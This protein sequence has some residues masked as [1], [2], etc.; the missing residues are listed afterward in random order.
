MEDTPLVSVFITSYNQEDFIEEAILSVA[1]QEYENIQII[2]SDDGSTDSSPAILKRLQGLFLEKIEIHLHKE[3]RGSTWNHNFSYQ[4]CRGEYI[5]YFDGDDI[6]LPGKIGDQLNFML[7]NPKYSLT[8]H[9]SEVFN[10]DKPKEF[11]LWNHRFGSRTGTVK[12]VIRYGNFL[13]SLGIMFKKS[14]EKLEFNQKISLSADWL[15]WIDLLAKTKGR[16]GYLDQVLGRYRRHDSNR[17]L[18]WR[19]KLTNHFLILDIVDDLYPQFR[20]QARGRRADSLLMEAV[21]F[22]GEKEKRLAGKSLINSF[23]LF[24]PNIFAAFRLPSR[25]I[26]FILRSRMKLDSL[27]KSLIR[28]D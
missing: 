27:I 9:N 7:A 25:E 14:P 21:Y 11:Y 26:I 16:I 8:Y 2:V 23:G 22:Y 19:Q 28:K 1:R 10:S 4:Q 15:F 18:I 20:L 24:F 6:M 17:T 13:P 5:C 3:N 12:E